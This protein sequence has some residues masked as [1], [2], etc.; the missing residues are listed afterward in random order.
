MVTPGAR[1][2]VEIRKAGAPPVVLGALRKDEFGHL[3][4]QALPGNTEVLY[5]SYPLSD[6]PADANVMVQ[7]ID[8]HTHGPL[9]TPDGHSVVFTVNGA[10]QIVENRAGSVP[11]VLSEGTGPRTPY[12]WLPDGKT[13]VFTEGNQETGADIW[14]MDPGTNDAPTLLVRTSRDDRH[15]AVSPNG[16]WL[17]FTSEENGQAEVFV[18]PLNRAG[19]RRRVSLAGGVSPLWAPDGRRLYWRRGDD[20]VS[21]DMN[22][23]GAVQGAPVIRATGAFVSNSALYELRDRPCLARIPPRRPVNTVNVILNLDVEIERLIS[24]A[25]AKR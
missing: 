22:A 19:P 21:V 11:R 2:L 12:A 5:V 23:A 8:A 9:F 15:P 10:L 16:S 1:E 7:P 13:L 14:A 25:E 3:F 18:Q 4:P 20:V 17:A 6:V 24:E